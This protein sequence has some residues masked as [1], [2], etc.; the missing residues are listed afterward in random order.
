M[1]K[2]NIF[3]VFFSWVIFIYQS[4]FFSL[5]IVKIQE[6]IVVQSNIFGWILMKNILVSSQNNFV[7]DII[8]Y[9]IYEHKTIGNKKILFIIKYKYKSL[10]SQFL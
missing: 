1:L 9:I 8:K 6:N 2:F 3:W 4:S 10:I 5:N 7:C